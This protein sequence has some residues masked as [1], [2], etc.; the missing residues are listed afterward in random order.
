M[1]SQAQMHPITRCV[2]MEQQPE[3]LLSLVLGMSWG[4]RRPDPATEAALLHC[5]T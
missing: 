2:R 4:T 5:L 3:K 1:L